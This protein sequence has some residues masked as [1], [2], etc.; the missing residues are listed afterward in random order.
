MTR[1]DHHFLNSLNG[2]YTEFQ[3]RPGNGFWIADG[4]WLAVDCKGEIGSISNSVYTA[5]KA[6]Q[7]RGYKSAVLVFY[8]E[9][10]HSR[11]WHEAVSLLTMAGFEHILIVDGGLRL[12]VQPGRFIRSRATVKHRTS[13]RFLVQYWQYEG[14][15]GRD[16]TNL[17]QSLG[18]LA[19]PNR[20]LMT[21]ALWE[22]GLEPYGLISS[23]WGDATLNL[24]QR[25]DFV[26][27]VPMG[28]RERLPANLGDP[29]HEQ[30]SLDPK[31][32][33]CIFNLV[34]ETHAVN[35]ESTHHLAHN[36]AWAKYE[37]PND[38]LFFTEK[39]AKAFAQG[40][41]PLFLSQ[42]GYVEQLRFEGFDVFDDLIDH[43]YDTI[44][45]LEQ[46]ITAIADE[47]QRLCSLGLHH[48][49]REIDLKQSRLISNYHNMRNVAWQ[50]LRL[51]NEELTRYRGLYE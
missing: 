23:G 14:L 36:T 11:E 6:N 47:L 1:P 50:N 28:Y 13:P 24:W 49:Q 19:R 17:F 33:Q 10:F 42:P 5:Y 18:R 40:Q 16:R 44:D 38:R 22:R 20:A 25:R 4:P 39:T 29:N 34:Q 48:W 21:C 15:A 8:D 9:A 51:I 26:S 12:D 41:F 27:C 37:Q 3:L 2:T 30:H 46:R 32:K 35:I 31:F 7:A 45:D 43:S